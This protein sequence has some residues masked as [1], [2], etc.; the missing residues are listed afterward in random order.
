[1][2]KYK[3]TLLIN[4]KEYTNYSINYL[5]YP[6][7]FIQLFIPEYNFNTTIYF[8][9]KSIINELYILGVTGFLQSGYISDDSWFT[10][11]IEW[12]LEEYE[13]PTPPAK[14]TALKSHS[15][16]EDFKFKR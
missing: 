6:T 9:R 16:I 3:H 14:P 13:R 4:N 5:A 11:Y 8:D 15:I 10:I 7:D 2:V 12:K 1:M